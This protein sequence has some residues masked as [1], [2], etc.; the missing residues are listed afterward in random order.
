M[1]SASIANSPV[2][3]LPVWMDTILPRFPTLDRDIEVDV[4]IVGAGL[5]G[6]T[7]A[8]LLR[9]EGVSVALL[10]HGLVAAADTGRTTAHLTCVT[11]ARLSELVT[12]FGKST[13]KAVW[14]AGA[15]AIDRIANIAAQTGVDCDF[16][17]LPGYLH[18]PQFR[19]PSGDN[20]NELELLH[21]DAALAQEFGFKA[22]LVESVPIVNQPGIRFE[23]QAKFHPRK[24]LKPLLEAIPND[25]SYVFEMT[26]FQNI[27]E[28]P[29]AVR[30]NG[31]RIRCQYLVIATH[32]PIINKGRTSTLD[33]TRLA[34]YTSYVLGARLP[35]GSLTE[36]LFWDT[37]DPYGYLRVDDELDHQYAIVGGED[38]KV[39]HGA[40]A[41]ASYNALGTRLLKLAPGA[42][43]EHQWQGQV[44][45]SDDGL[46]FIGER[47]HREFIATGFCGN[48]F[49]FGTLSAFM[50]RD[51]FL[52]RKNPWFDLF[53]LE[54]KRATAI[55]LT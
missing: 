55:K 39:G 15:V 29:F 4:V 50:A 54:R 17:R 52:N 28:H 25:S 43:I 8:Y 14:Q 11:D 13:A 1:I 12:R 33:Q 2:A 51:R 47:A 48:G 38:V 36:G 30:A 37:G 44:V 9:Q 5:T 24:Y 42:R 26:A 40:N 16:S 6:I 32:N 27:E 41:I 20:S 34:L 31:K 7:T 19:T 21:I 3:A 23:K 35:Q 45:M 10:E 18:S 22:E 49:T 53:C 46:P